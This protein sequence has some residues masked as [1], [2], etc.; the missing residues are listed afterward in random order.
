MDYNSLSEEQQYMIDVARTGQNILVDA[1]IGSGK[2][3]TI[4]VLCN[5]LGNK[6]ILYLTYNKLL[7]IDAKEKIKN[8]YA[9]VTNYHGFAYMELARIGIHVGQSDLIQT[10]LRKKPK[11]SRLYDV[12]IVDEY[13][14]IE[15][16]ISLMLQM[17]KEQC[18]NI[19]IIAVGDMAQKIY[20]KT[21][22][23]VVAFINRFLE[24]HVELSFTK[25]FRIC[26]DLASE[27]GRV[28]KK[29]INGQNK[30]CTVTIMS[31]DE[32]EEYIA[33]KEVGD[34]LCLGT[35]NGAMNTLLNDL[36]R[37]YPE[38]FNK[39][40]VYASIQD[41]DKG[42]VTP[43]KDTAIFT[44]FD[45][46]KGLERNVCVV[47][48]YT[49]ANWFMR[50]NIPNMNG[51]VLRN[52]FCVAASRGKKE[53]VFVKGEDDKILT[54]EIL[55]S[56]YTR[57]NKEFIKPF[58][59]SD[60][61]S[62]KFKEDVEDCFS[63]IESKQLP[64]DDKFEIDVK[65]KDELIDLAPCIGIFQEQ[66][67]FGNYNI[68]EQIEYSKDM[69]RNMRQMQ[70]EDDS[71]IEEK[72]LYLTARETGQERYYKQVTVPFISEYQAD[73]IKDRLRTVFNSQEIVQQDCSIEF[74]N[75]RKSTVVEIRGRIDVYKD[76]M[77]YE[78]KFVDGLTHE[79]FLQLACYLIAFNIKKGILWNVK[80]N[81]M[82]EV[83][84]PK[85][86]TFLMQVLKTITKG[87]Y[88]G[89]SLLSI[90]ANHA[91]IE[92]FSAKTETVDELK[93]LL[94][95]KNADSGVLDAVKQLHHGKSKKCKKKKRKKHK[96]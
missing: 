58:F 71:S 67:F 38:K 74:K 94:E 11:L 23:D 78:L 86:K 72:I 37:H 57:G 68:D 95:N 64:V 41:E 83:T 65:S 26:P 60:M 61:F 52:I 91:V 6:K 76:G 69:H 17:I 92:E 25:C 88:N 46:C 48:D 40:T 62:F 29:E 16:E 79:H 10:F 2:T 55:S 42:S 36:E 53:I 84:V 15:E 28:W 20:D 66:S 75:K 50:Q 81:E 87:I 21:K 47:F 82:Y 56:Y 34:V 9:M 35:R 39:R 59:I 70:L 77:I 24:E 31:S 30:D 12:L 19:Q 63:L 80:K 89:K 18:P 8:S 43:S 90:S 85:R 44:T 96:K 14:D 1:C 54:E 33:G 45:G 4:Q 49:E 3:T 22:L 73:L 32:V 93:H 51:E 7:K 13:Q 5:M 27:L